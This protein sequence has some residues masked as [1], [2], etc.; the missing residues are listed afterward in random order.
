MRKL[1]KSMISRQFVYI[2]A[3]VTY[4]WDPPNLGVPKWSNGGPRGSPRPS[5][6]A[7]RP[8]G[9]RGS[10]GPAGQPAGDPAGQPA[11]QIGQFLAKSGQKVG[12]I[13]PNWPIFGQFRI[14]KWPKLAQ[15]GPKWPIFGQKMAIFGHF[16]AL[17][18]GSRK[19]K[20][21]KKRGG[22]THY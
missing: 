3:S 11:G 8:G 22:I 7:S 6:P 13:W 12:Q 4:T 16:S 9:P 1:V 17:F 15:N 2:Y 20:Y 10:P 14:Q 19:V 18:W 5:W 21:R